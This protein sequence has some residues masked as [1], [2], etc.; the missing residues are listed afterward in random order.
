MPGTYIFVH[1]LGQRAESWKGVLSSMT[2]RRTI[3][4]P[5]LFPDPTEGNVSYEDLYA[6]FRDRCARTEG[7]LHLCGLSLGGVLALDYA[8]ERPEQVASLVLIG[9]PYKLPK[10]AF[11]LQS[12]VFRLMPAAAFRDMGLPK[13]GILA[14]TASMKGLAPGGKAPMVQCPTLVL[15]GEKDRANRKSAGFFAQ[16]VQ[17]AALATIPQSGHA[18]NEEAPQAL[19]AA[20]EDFYARLEG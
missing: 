14:L 8:A 19:A 15:C 12:A 9:T 10:A 3:L 18:V 2:G 16:S 7:P 13:Q 5:E 1:G 6:A 11:A 17:N 4:C 20:L